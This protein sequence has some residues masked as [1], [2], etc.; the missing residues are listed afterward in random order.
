MAISY[1]IAWQSTEPTWND[2]DRIRCFDED[3][4]ETQYSPYRMTTE[5]QKCISL[6]SEY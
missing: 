1:G 2:D 4:E 3:H 6:K 5:T